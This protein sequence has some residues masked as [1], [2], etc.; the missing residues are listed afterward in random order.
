MYVSEIFDIS[1]RLYFDTAP[2]IYYVERNKRYFEPMDAIVEHIE[3]HSLTC[4]SSVITLT[5]VLIH[6]IREGAAEI[7]QKYRDIL[8]Q[9]AILRLI[10]VTI[11]I[12]ELAA[13]LRVNHN[14][15]T[16][17]AL[18]L[19]AAIISG[20]GVFLTNDKGLKRVE[21][22]RVL[23]LDDVERYPE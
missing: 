20:C 13:R 2:L 23:V 10:P 19:A 17:D 1:D 12:A 21:N 11:Q 16:P 8:T 4:V 15:R 22:I 5:E 14:L 7:E 9:N 3:S 6:P 18:H